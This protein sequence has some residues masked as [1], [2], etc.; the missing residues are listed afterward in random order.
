M[1]FQDFFKATTDRVNGKAARGE[2]VAIRR[3]DATAF[4]RVLCMASEKTE[5]LAPNTGGR[6]APTVTQTNTVYFIERLDS[7][8]GDAIRSTLD[9]SNVFRVKAV[10]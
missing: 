6:C 7:I 8:R 4:Y 2:V 10:R 3:D 1:Y 5:T 9:G